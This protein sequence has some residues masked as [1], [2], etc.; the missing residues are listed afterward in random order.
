MKNKYITLYAIIVIFQ[1][2]KEAFTYNESVPF[3]FTQTPNY[4]YQEDFILSK[5]YRPFVDDIY[6]IRGCSSDERNRNYQNNNSGYQLRLVNI[7]FEPS[8]DYFFNKDVYPPSDRDP[9]TS[10]TF[11]IISIS[12]L[13]DAYSRGSHYNLIAFGRSEDYHPIP[14][15]SKKTGKPIQY[16]GNYAILPARAKIVPVQFQ[17]TTDYNFSYSDYDIYDYEVLILI[18]IIS[19]QMI[20]IICVH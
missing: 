14:K 11:K 15:I 12:P 2:L 13:F 18:G 9:P 17:E 4:C 5:E 7:T 6:P 1:I 16:I 10:M 20:F 3:N 19:V 8:L